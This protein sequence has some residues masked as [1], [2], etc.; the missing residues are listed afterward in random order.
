M[1]LFYFGPWWDWKTFIFYTLISIS[2]IVLL[3]KG[4]QK[5]K[6]LFYFGNLKYSPG[7]IYYVIAFIILV[8]FSI[9]RSVEVG[10]DTIT[11][12]NS[13]RNATDFS[14]NWETMFLLKQK[15][16]LYSLY[17]FLLRK[18]S[19][20]YLIYFLVTYSIIT[21]AVIRFVKSCFNKK[22]H[23]TVLIL[24]ILLF[25]YHFSAIRSGLSGAFILLSFCYLKDNKIL[26]ALLFTVVA[27]LFHYT[28]VINILFIFVYKLFSSN[29]L[30]SR[31]TIA[32]AIVT[33]LISS[34]YVISFLQSSLLGTK[35]SYYISYQGT[36]V[37]NAFIILLA[38]LV[39]IY[40]KDLKKQ[41]GSNDVFLYSTLY[42]ASLVPIIVA[43]GAYRV[44]DI[45]F[46][47]R[48]VVWSNI[49]Q[50]FIEKNRGDPH[51]VSLINITIIICTLS[52]LVFKM[53]R[54]AEANNIM[55]Y[56]TM[57]LK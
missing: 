51:I 2:T 3:K 15:E 24:F 38:I 16:P 57:F 20:N 40:F 29:I 9:L 43:T 44:P 23:Y 13:F 50:Y 8:L 17:I 22:S 28:A 32:L 1:Q 4:E 21:Y 36:L 33:I 56:F 37:G 45:Y 47:P 18:V 31:Y 6:Y 12:V 19:N 35:Y 25:V 39:W 26:K 10:T 48:L 42:I 53:I 55:P 52:Y 7:N 41:M 46:W 54:I 14:F 30:K 11:Y 34:N 27:T 5:P 49:C